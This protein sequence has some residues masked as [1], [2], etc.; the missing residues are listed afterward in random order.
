MIRK[1]G[2]W[3]KLCTENFDSL[4]YNFKSSW[5]MEDLGKAVC[6][7]MTFRYV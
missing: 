2:Q 6:K 4:N 3:G 1:N 5:S 7:A